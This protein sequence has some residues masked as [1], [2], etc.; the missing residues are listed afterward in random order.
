MENKVDPGQSDL[1]LYCL[2]RPSS[3]YIKKFMLRT[4]MGLGGWV[5]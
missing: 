3:F 5:R 2:L 1:D 4:G